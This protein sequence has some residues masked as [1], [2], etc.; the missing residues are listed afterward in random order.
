MTGELSCTGCKHWQVVKF[1]TPHAPDGVMC[2][3]EDRCFR[4]ATTREGIGWSCVFETADS[5]DISRPNRCGPGR[6][7]YERP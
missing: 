3:F 7:H 6:K 2:R 4:F 1:D 5:P